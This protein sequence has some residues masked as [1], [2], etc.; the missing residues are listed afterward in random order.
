MKAFKGLLLVYF[1]TKLKLQLFFPPHIL[2]SYVVDIFDWK[3][4]DLK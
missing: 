4:M 1:E 2:L 3:V